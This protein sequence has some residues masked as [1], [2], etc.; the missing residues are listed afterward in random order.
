MSTYV[1]FFVVFNFLN[2]CVWGCVS[3]CLVGNIFIR[4]GDNFVTTKIATKMANELNE[5]EIKVC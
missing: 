4:V 3:S 5:S 2:Y 1:E